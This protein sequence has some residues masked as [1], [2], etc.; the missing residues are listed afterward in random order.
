MSDANV[1]RI[2]AFAASALAA[3][4]IFLI[5]R[6]YARLR[7]Q[8]LSESVSAGV[9]RERARRSVALAALRGAAAA[10]GP[11]STARESWENF[12]AAQAEVERIR[13]GVRKCGE[14]SQWSDGWSGVSFPSACPTPRH[15][16]IA[17]RPY[18]QTNPNPADALRLGPQRARQVAQ[19][20]RL[21]ALAQYR[22]G[23]I[24]HSR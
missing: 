5:Q 1:A 4:I 2:G 7:A 21:F 14:G 9:E 18:P 8:R 22:H 15:L 17:R 16:D 12:C 3:I 23:R 11:G 19:H 20:V 13:E 10:A 6:H 24:L